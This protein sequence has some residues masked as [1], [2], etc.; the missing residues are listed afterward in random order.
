MSTF[1]FKLNICF[2]F[3]FVYVYVMFG[4][5][6]DWI[7]SDQIGWDGMGLKRIESRHAA[8]GL[9]RFLCFLCVFENVFLF[10]IFIAA[11]I[12]S[13]SQKTS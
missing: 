12:L 3:C 9:A 11:F 1:K 8:L 10:G 13:S 2:V 7:G 5:G 4:I 6:S